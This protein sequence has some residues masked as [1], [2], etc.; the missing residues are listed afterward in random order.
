MRIR[1]KAWARPEL[2]ACSYYIDRPEE[3][4]G[5]WQEGFGRPRPCTWIWAAGNASFWH[6][7]LTPSRT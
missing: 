3:K 4:K 5:R 6:R 2:A 7:P 1:K